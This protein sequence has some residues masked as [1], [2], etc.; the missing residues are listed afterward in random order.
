MIAFLRPNMKKLRVVTSTV[1]EMTNRQVALTAAS[2]YHRVQQRFAS[3]SEII[4]RARI[5]LEF[6]EEEDER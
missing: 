4:V 5:Y 1:S 3:A 6:L 2:D